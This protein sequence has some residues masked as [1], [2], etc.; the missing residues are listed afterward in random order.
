MEVETAISIVYEVIMQSA[1]S[2]L[3]LSTEF[4]EIG[5]GEIKHFHLIDI[6]CML[7]LTSNKFN[8]L[9]QLFFIIIDVRTMST[10][11]C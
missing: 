11:S 9:V 4:I 5:S 7:T 6:F 8:F 2:Q 10:A 1:V 3:N